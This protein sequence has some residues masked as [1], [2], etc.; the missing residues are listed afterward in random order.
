MSDYIELEKKISEALKKNPL[1]LPEVFSIGITNME[2]Y[3]RECY[4]HNNENLQ[5]LAADLISYIEWT[6]TDKARSQTA[7]YLLPIYGKYFSY[8][9]KQKRTIDSMF[10]S[11]LDRAAFKWF[12]LYYFEVKGRDPA[13]ERGHNIS[14][15]QMGNLRWDWDAWLS[16]TENRIIWSKVHPAGEEFNLVVKHDDETTFYKIPE[17]LKENAET[18]TKA[19][20]ARSRRDG[21]GEFEFKWVSQNIA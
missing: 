7:E 21:N 6:I 13:W 8:V 4:T 12:C 17:D 20:Y 14:N 11:G 5:K 9:Y 19:I 2:N 10:V 1:L 18:W 3:R 16:E 15:T